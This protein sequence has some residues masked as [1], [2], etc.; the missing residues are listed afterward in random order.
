[1]PVKKNLDS[2]EEDYDAG[3]IQVLKGLE[4]VN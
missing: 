3:D 2:E 4:G 1:M